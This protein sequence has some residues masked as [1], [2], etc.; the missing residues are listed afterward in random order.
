MVSMYE[1]D[2]VEITGYLMIQAFDYLA[3]MI[4]L[5]RMICPC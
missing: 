4:K 5:M 3:S 2:D 1:N